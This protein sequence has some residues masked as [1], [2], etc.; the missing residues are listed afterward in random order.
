MKRA[1]ITVIEPNPDGVTMRRVDTEIEI[2]ATDEKGGATIIRILGE[3]K[4]N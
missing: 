2:V 3:A 4:L 1:R